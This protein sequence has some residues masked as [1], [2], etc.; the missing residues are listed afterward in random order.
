MSSELQNQ[1]FFSDLC[2]HLNEL[3]S[4][5]QGG[6]KTIIIRYT[7]IKAFEAKLQIFR[8]DANSK[9]F[10]YFKITKKYFSKTLSK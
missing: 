1:C 6:Y 10:D 9:T 5:L 4:N 7:L 2:L 8:R 3:N